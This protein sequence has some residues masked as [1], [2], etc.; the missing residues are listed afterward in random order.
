MD[1]EGICVWGYLIGQETLFLGD[2]LIPWLVL[3]LGAALV[4]ANIAVVVRPP[5]ADPRDPDSPRR[6]PPPLGRVVP[7]IGLGV[8]LS[9]WALASLVSS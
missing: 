1:L 7:W 2:D 4:V 8:L 5:R 3:A 6:E 9:A